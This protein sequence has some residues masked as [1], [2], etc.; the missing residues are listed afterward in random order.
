MSADGIVVPEQEPEPTPKALKEATSIASGSLRRYEMVQTHIHRAGLCLFW[1]L[2]IA[3]GILSMI[4]AWHLGAPEKWRF[5]T[6]EQQSDLQK[7]L[8]AGV[9]SSAATQ[10]SR[11]WLGNKSACGEDPD[12]E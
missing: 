12:Q 4:W 2:V 6:T 10:L 1:V 3:V 7:T 8:L 5:L 11:K 9:G